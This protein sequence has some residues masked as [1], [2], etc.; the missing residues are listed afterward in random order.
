MDIPNFLETIYYGDRGCAA[1]VIDSWKQ[2][3][4]IQVAPSLS[5]VRGP[6][7]N[8]YTA[9][10]LE[11]GF[12]VFEGVTSFALTPSGPLPEGFIWDITAEPVPGAP[13]KFLVTVFTDGLDEHGE[14]T[15][16]EL[17][18]HATSMALEDPRRSGERIRT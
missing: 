1:V 10:D 4:K 5:R 11:N 17:R 16:V 2:E 7:W 15:S 14:S 13:E 8:F 18:L 3:I 12:I 6:A 9:E